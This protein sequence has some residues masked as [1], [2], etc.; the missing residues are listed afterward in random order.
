MSASKLYDT[1]V[2]GGGP[3][4]CSAAL[5]LAYHKRSVLVLDRG[6][7]PMCFHTNSIMNY[8]AGPT[9]FE[10]R[11]L[12][13]QLQGLAESAGASFKAADVVEISRRYPD[14]KLRTEK[15]L[16][17]KRRIRLSLQDA[18]LRDRHRTKTS[19]GR[20]QMETLAASR[21]CRERCILLS[22][23]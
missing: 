13:R 22:G 2:I 4:G 18:H 20:W 16:S 12:L 8:A 7:S 19:I 9:Y 15:S 6:T 3:A 10:G 5:H 17:N 21:R 14:F 11:T 1:I 23:L